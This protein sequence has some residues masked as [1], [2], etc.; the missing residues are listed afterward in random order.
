MKLNGTPTNIKDALLSN[1]ENKKSKVAASTYRT[2]F[3]K[4]KQLINLI[5]NKE[6]QNISQSDWNLLISQLMDKYS[7][8]TVNQYLVL[9]RSTL[10]TAVQNG[11]LDRNPIA[12]HKFLKVG[13][14]LPDP[15]SRNEISTL[16]SSSGYDSEKQLIKLGISTGLRISELLAVSSECF[17]REAKTLLIDQSLV[18]GNYVA[19]KTLSSERLVELTKPAFDA[20][21]KLVALSA[22]FE[23]TTYD[24]TG[25]DRKKVVR[26]RKLLARSTESGKPYHSVDNFRDSFFVN[27]CDLMRV[28]YR[29]PKNFRHTFACQ[30]LTANA[31]LVWIT[32]QLG[33]SNFD[34]IRKHYG[35]WMHHDSSKAYVQ[36]V[37]ELEEMCSPLATN[38][39]V[40]LGT[41]TTKVI[42]LQVKKE[43]EIASSKKN[44][45]SLCKWLRKIRRAA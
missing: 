8:R 20:M 45:W 2:D 5:G 29:P 34:T 21:E 30:M 19:T 38:E 23:P 44:R 40:Y 10:E 27:Y 36:A 37:N 31:P 15:F 14:C 43:S 33:H 13:N 16:L 3:N 35:K 7:A 12:V 18:N 9:L 25:N 41:E 42:S 1:V 28:R 39:E 17:N 32:G 4:T 6:I 24:F 11:L 26:Q 22:L